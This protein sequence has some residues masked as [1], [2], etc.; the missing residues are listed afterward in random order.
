MCPHFARR[1]IAGSACGMGGGRSLPFVQSDDGRNTI[2]TYPCRSGACRNMIQ[3]LETMQ[4]RGADGKTTG[5]AMQRAHTCGSEIGQPAGE[6][7][8][9][10]VEA[11]VRNALVR[12][13]NGRMQT[14]C[15][16]KTIQSTEM[17]RFRTGIAKVFASGILRGTAGYRSGL[18]VNTQR[19]A[20]DR[21]GE[22]KTRNCGA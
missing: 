6:H 14:E 17:Y 7:L 1:T 11:G 15:R 8:P 18:C 10:S 21:S 2:R 12:K 13:I 5:L 20:A 9:R 16:A 22:E 3:W 4:I 19:R